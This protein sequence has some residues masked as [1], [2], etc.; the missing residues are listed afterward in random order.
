MH[1]RESLHEKKRQLGHMTLIKFFVLFKR[2]PARITWFV[3]NTTG[4][5]ATWLVIRFQYTSFQNGLM[6]A[7]YERLES[8][9]TANYFM[10]FTLYI[11]C[12]EKCALFSS[13]S[14]LSKPENIS[15]QK[16]RGL[17][18]L[19]SAIHG[20]LALPPSL[21]ILVQCWTFSNNAI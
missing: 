11:F 16:F 20:F 3:K 6:W 12:Q 13:C 15:D 1:T 5:M 8:I 7:F 10:H 2:I 21:S 19:S 9:I 18:S 17:M 4:A 14:K